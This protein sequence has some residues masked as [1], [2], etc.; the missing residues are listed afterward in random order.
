MDELIEYQGQ[1]HGS[2]FVEHRKFIDA[3]RAGDAPE[4]SVRDGLLSVAVGAAAQQSIDEKRLVEL[5][6]LI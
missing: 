3:V 5:A 1:H 4:V 2:S 6:E